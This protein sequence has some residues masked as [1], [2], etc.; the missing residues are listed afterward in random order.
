[1]SKVKNVVKKVDGYS[2]DEGSLIKLHN[3]VKAYE[4][5]TGPVIA[6]KDINLHIR[7]REFLAVVGKSGSGK[8]TLLNIIA[9][10]DRPTSGE[11][12]VNGTT[13]GSLLEAELAEWRGQNV[14][15]VFQFFH[16]YQR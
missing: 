4:S 15:L 5:P 10:I 6:L 8:T 9:G 11:A 13:L 1:M 12:L 7:A 2:P 14:G 3:I 16:Y